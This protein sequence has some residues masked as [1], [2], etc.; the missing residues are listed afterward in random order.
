M[1]IDPWG[2][3]LARA[4]D[5]AAV[6]SAEIDLDYLARVRRELPALAHVRLDR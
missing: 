2:R 4:G 1:L 6:V 5:G 3:V